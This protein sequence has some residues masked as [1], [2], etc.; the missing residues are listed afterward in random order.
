L[1]VVAAPVRENTRPVASPARKMMGT[2][3]RAFGGGSASAAVSK[4]NWEEF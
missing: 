2:V 3:A 4:D 1:R